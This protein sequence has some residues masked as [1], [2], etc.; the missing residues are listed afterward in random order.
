MKPSPLAGEGK[1][2]ETFELGQKNSP[3]LAGGAAGGTPIFCYQ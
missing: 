1:N 3:P 2:R